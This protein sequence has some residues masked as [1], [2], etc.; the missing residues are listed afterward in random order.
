MSR[1]AATFP[2]AT[3][4]TILASILVCLG[5]L[6]PA[7]AHAGLLDS[8][9][10]TDSLRLAEEPAK[11]Y[12]SSLGATL[13]E[14]SEAPTLEPAPADDGIVFEPVDLVLP[15][16]PSDAS[17]PLL[18][19]LQQIDAPRAWFFHTGSYQTVVA[20]VD[21]GIDYTHEDLYENI[22]LNENEIPILIRMQLQDV[23]GDGILGF[24]DLNDPV[25]Q[26]PGLI[27]DSNANGRIDG[28]DALD[29]WSDG[30]DGL[31]DGNGYVDD[32][33]GWDFVDDD[34][35]PMDTD[36][37][38]THVAGTIGAMANTLHPGGSGDG[39]TR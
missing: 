17:F 14:G 13:L 36:A 38:G 32:L 3:P 23:D 25:N 22:W 6:A 5:G 34:N 31:L 15:V 12:A 1:L 16:Y 24:R 27:V 4:A 10:S 33:I 30:I 20:V 11:D 26:G 35:D 19:G 9:R 18:W 37:H 21:T 29:Q 2:T 7:P 8:A 39:L 28:G